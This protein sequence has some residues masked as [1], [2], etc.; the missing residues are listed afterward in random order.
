LGLERGDAALGQVV[1]VLD[2][3]AHLLVGLLEEL[4]AVTPFGGLEDDEGAPVIPFPD[5]DRAQCEFPIGGMEADLSV[6][7]LELD[8]VTVTFVQG[9]T[10]DPPLGVR[11]L[12]DGRQIENLGINL[13]GPKQ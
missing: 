4:A 8:I 13:N 11:D 12:G 2:A 7:E 5:H 6:S 9:R 3:S 1:I 10:E